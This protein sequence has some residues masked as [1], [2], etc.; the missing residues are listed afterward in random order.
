VPYHLAAISF[1]LLSTLSI[2]AALRLLEIR[3]WRCY[4]AVF[5][6]PSTLTAISV[7]T[8]TPLLLLG[9]AAAWRYR[10]RRGTAAVMVG[11][12]VSAKLFLWPLLVW[13]WVTGRRRTAA[14]AVTVAI[15]LAAASWAAVGFAGASRYPALLH[16]L[17]VTEAPHS[18]AG[19]WL[20][21]GTFLVALASAVGL[22][23]ALQRP[24]RDRS[25]FAAAVIAS[26]LFTPILWLH[27]L[28]LLGLALPR[29]FGWV[30]LAPAALWLTASHDS[31]GAWWRVLLVAIV[32]TAVAISATH[33]V[34]GGLSRR[35]GDGGLPGQDAG[36]LGRT[37]A[38]GT[39]A[40]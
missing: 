16:R 25:A 24:W 32:I 22:A 12:T 29:R 40:G 14:A 8:L 1:A 7:G 33:G 18:Y 38:R 23:V 34:P 26:L 19:L 28:L 36:S 13:L 10:D 2:V 9:A 21:G 6:W 30:W 4:G 17:T 27:Y 39:G 3:D 11:L 35:R 15:C 5:L 37:V 20:V 31:H